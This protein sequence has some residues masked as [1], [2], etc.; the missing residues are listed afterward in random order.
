M[1]ELPE[2]ETIVQQLRKKVLGKKID[3]IDILVKRMV[4]NNVKEIVGEKFEKVSR[5]AK[6][7]ILELSNSKFLVISLRM[8]GHFHY[9]DKKTLSQLKEFDKFVVMRMHFQDGSI[10]THNSIR[11][12]GD[13]K[14]LNLKELNNVFNKLGPEPLEKEF[15]AKK[16]K[17]MLSDKKKSNIKTI[18]MDQSFIAGIGNIYAQEAL[19]IAKIDPNRKVGSL[20]DNQIKLLHEGLIRML[21]MAVKNHG[22]TVE[23]YVHIEGSGGFQKYLTVY[24][25]EKCPKGHEIKKIKIGGRGTYYC[26]KCQK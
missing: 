22:T 20:N 16:F 13:I 25:K 26:D 1:P 2:V 15:N 21:E 11:R 10:L 9:A 14:L 4:G 7:I 24:G 12:F 23:N 3:S 19:Y 8:T 5:R 6:Y 18:L 17:E